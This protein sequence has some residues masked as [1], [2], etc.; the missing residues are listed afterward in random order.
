MTMTMGI[1]KHDNNKVCDNQ[2]DVNTVYDCSMQAMT[3][4]E[5]MKENIS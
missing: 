5:W 4:H 3:D 2:M 1:L